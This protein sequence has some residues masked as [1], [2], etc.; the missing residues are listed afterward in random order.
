MIKDW[1]KYAPYFSKKEF[2][3]Q[4][5]GENAMRQEF[6]DKLCALRKAYGKSMVITSGYRSTK[7]S[8]ESKKSEPGSHSSGL[9]CDVKVVG[10]DAYNLMKCAIDIGFT[11]IGVHRSFIH[12]DIM[13]SRSIAPRPSVW[14]Y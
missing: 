13:P 6:M 2:D 4:E 14:P 11:G 5:T 12:L 8:I 1:S 10:A 9:A 7:H 3:C